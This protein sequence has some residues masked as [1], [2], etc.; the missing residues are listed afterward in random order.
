M[1]V[2]ETPLPNINI[3][4]FRNPCNNNYNIVNAIACHEHKHTDAYCN[5]AAIVKILVG[6]NVI[7]V[8]KPGAPNVSSPLL[9]LP[10]KVSKCPHFHQFAGQKPNKQLYS[11]SVLSFF[12][13]LLVLLIVIGYVNHLCFYFKENLTMVDFEFQL[14]LDQG[15]VILQANLHDIIS[16][17]NGGYLK[18]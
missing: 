12:F 2:K 9:S 15:L 5:F 8:S 13:F 16:K 7:S 6:A 4:F 3:Y 11:V 14:G 17:I 18:Q 10:K 1:R